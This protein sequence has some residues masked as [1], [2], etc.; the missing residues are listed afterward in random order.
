M[1]LETKDRCGPVRALARGRRAREVAVAV[2]GV[3]AYLVFS[4]GDTGSAPDSGAGSSA[5]AVVTTS[6]LP[7]PGALGNLDWG[8]DPATSEAWTAD[9][10]RA[11][12]T[13]GDDPVGRA[14]R[15]VLR[16]A[17]ETLGAEAL[18]QRTL[19]M[20]A[21]LFSSQSYKDSDAAVRTLDE[22]FHW[23]LCARIGPAELAPR[24]RVKAQAAV[25]GWSRTYVPTGNPIDEANLFYLFLAVDVLRPLLQ[26]GDREVVDDW[27]ADFDGASERYEARLGRADTARFNNRHTWGLANVALAAGVRGD[28]GRVARIAGAMAL[29][30]N[31]NVGA[32]GATTDF[33]QRDAL[34][35]HVYDLE[36]YVRAAAL[37]PAATANAHLQ[38]AKGL[39][40][41]A[42]FYKGEQTHLEFAN[43]TV[44][45][46]VK[47]REAGEAEW[48]NAPWEPRHARELLRLARTAFPEV[49]V[50][51]GD[52][53]GAGDFH[54]IL[55]LLCALKGD[56]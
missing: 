29:Q 17:E 33:H 23:S 27:L 55:K 40:F 34:H 38:I 14:A 43:T 30:A 13:L 1:K 49:R 51:T 53:A 52:L 31:S 39:R 32:D 37:V 6:T 12:L 10:V 35:Y 20:D 2:A 50:W 19:D 26:D 16:H 28:P 8:T 9:G 15:S 46:D 44:D 5:D 21:E 24:C 7:P 41:L 25:L 42:P 18:P 56:Y 54:P 47:R 3:A 22:V 45:M 4:C 36:A 11:T 48:Q